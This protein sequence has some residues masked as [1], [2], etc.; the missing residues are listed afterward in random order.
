[1]AESGEKYAV[2]LIRSEHIDKECSTE[3]WVSSAME[4]QIVD[5]L[6]NPHQLYVTSMEQFF[7]GGMPQQCLAM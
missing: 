7:N 5:C 6:Y 1:M 3:R 4:H 2:Y